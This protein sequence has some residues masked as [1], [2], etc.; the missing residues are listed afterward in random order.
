MPFGSRPEGCFKRLTPA[1]L[2]LPC[3]QMQREVDYRAPQRMPLMMHVRASA[4]ACPWEPPLE[5][6]RRWKPTT[7]SI[8]HLLHTPEVWSLAQR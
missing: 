8:F 3:K 2:S 4:T 6:K 7:T 1:D 5:F